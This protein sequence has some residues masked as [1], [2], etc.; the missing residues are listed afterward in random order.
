MREPSKKEDLQDRSSS[1]K[2]WTPSRR[3][4]HRT[5]R[6]RRTFRHRGRAASPAWATEDP[7]WPP[8]APAPAALQQVTR[9]QRSETGQQRSARPDTGHQRSHTGQQR[10]ARPDTGHQ[11]SVTGHDRSA[12]SH[13]RPAA[14]HERSAVVVGYQRSVA[15][16]EVG[17]TSRWFS[18]R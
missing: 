6:S 7:S 15:G 10:S 13:Q 11:R 9:G 12:T 2:N 14:G 8:A 17:R 5:L 3:Y 4:T 1:D 18:L 16:H